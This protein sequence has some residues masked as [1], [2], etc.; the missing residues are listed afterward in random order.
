M[1]KK[2]L[3]TKLLVFQNSFR[4]K[5]NTLVAEMQNNLEDSDCAS[6]I[7]HLAIDFS[8]ITF[9]LGILRKDEYEWLMGF[10]CYSHLL[11]YEKNETKFFLNII[12]NWDS[13]DHRLKNN[14]YSLIENNCKT[15]VNIN[16]I[17][18][19]TKLTAID[20]LKTEKILALEYEIERLVFEFVNFLISE[21]SQETRTKELDNIKNIILTSKSPQLEFDYA[22]YSIEQLKEIG[23]ECDTRILN[24]SKIKDIRKLIVENQKQISEIDK[25]Y[26]LAFLKIHV[27]L[28]VQ[29]ELILESIDLLLAQKD[30][31]IIDLFLDSIKSQIRTYNIVYLNFINMVVCLCENQ[32]VIFY[33]LYSV[34]DGLGVFKTN[35]EKEVTDSLSLINISIDNMESN[36][37]NKLSVIEHQ[38]KNISQGVIELKAT[39]Q[40]SIIAIKN[41]ED[42]IGSCFASV[43]T[44]VGS[45]LNELSDDI[46]GYLT[47]IESGIAYNNLIST[48]NSYQLYK[49]N[50]NI[51][52]F[53]I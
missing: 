27:Y 48:V 29:I 39:M 50:S 44:A 2:P 46:S 19:L 3:K 11:N 31:S 17:Q 6:I 52:S 49:V 15:L 23:F 51:R 32:L 47:R 13:L 20:V 9:H 38:L 8:S 28:G 14:Y 33:E 4:N 1:L 12:N 7:R 18:E 40:Q 22:E 26:I 41:L 24:I 10:I 53:R 35:Y 43:Q 25:N 21:R 45:S 16:S 34:F 37:I 42:S 36:I 30:K 5:L